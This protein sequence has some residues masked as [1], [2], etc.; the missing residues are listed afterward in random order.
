[1]KNQ[2]RYLSSKIFAK[3]FAKILIWFSQ[4]SV[5]VFVFLA[6]ILFSKYIL[7]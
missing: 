1:M 2:K 5:I 6:T 3:I 7:E 4:R